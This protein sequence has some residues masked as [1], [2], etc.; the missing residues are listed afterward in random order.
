MGETIMNVR[1]GAVLVCMVAII[2][3]GCTSEDDVKEDESVVDL[4]EY[5][6]Y[7]IEI[8]GTGEN[9][10]WSWKVLDEDLCS[11]RRVSLR[12]FEIYMDGQ[13]WSSQTTV[14]TYCS[15]SGYILTAGNSSELG[16]E[17][18]DGDYR[19]FYHFHWE[20]ALEIKY[21]IHY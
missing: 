15:G 16:A 13:S 21:D 7:L 12:I 6:E 14:A 2:L 17:P 3:A 5:G 10:S 9:L 11:R 1:I 4:A 8:E 18:D 20:G 19:V